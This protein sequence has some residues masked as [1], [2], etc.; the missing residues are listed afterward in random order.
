MTRRWAERITAVVVGVLLLAG[1]A[2]IP[3]R[4]PVH[5]VRGKSTPEQNAVRYNPPGPV[6]GASA[7]QV[8]YGFLD[9]MLAYPVG[10]DVATEFLTDRAAETW[11]PGART[12]VYTQ[13]SITTSGASGDKARE[14]V[15]LSYTADASLSARGRYNDRHGR[16]ATVR[17]GLTKVDGEWRISDLPDGTMVSKQ[18][19]EDYYVPLSLYF[20]DRAGN[21]L[22]TDPVYQPEGDQ[23]ATTLTYALLRG[24]SGLLAGEARS[25]LPRGTS[26][27]VSVPV[28]DSG[29]ANVRL[30]GSVQTLSSSEL[31]RM[32]A[33]IVWTVGQAHGVNG[34]RIIVNG[35]PLNLPG[36]AQVESTDAWSRFDPT[37]AAGNAKAFAMHHGRLRVIS[38]TSVTEFA[39]P[40]GED[41]SDIVDF[42]VDPSLEKIAVVPPGRTS[43]QVASLSDREDITTVATGSGFLRPVWDL[44]DRLWLVERSRDSSTLTVIDD[45]SVDAVPLG[46]LARMVVTSFELS[47]DNTRFVAVARRGGRKKSVRRV[48][49]GAIRHGS[50]GDISGLANVRALRLADESVTGP[51]SATWRSSVGVVVLASLDG[52]YPQP[53]VARIDGSTV[54]GGPLSREP[55]LTDVGATSVVCSGVLAAPVY[56]A[57]RRGRL[58]VQDVNGRWEQMPGTPLRMVSYS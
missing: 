49:V 8:V 4:G 15:R 51:V 17:F 1:C 44:Q 13:P 9:A 58:W 2:T 37:G 5:D 10:T 23:L 33:Q 25:Y 12:Q 53:Y 47:P 34:V 48:Y 57:D 30:R 50:D 42:R 32:A 31:S 11:K 21:R 18:F 7:S 16:D 39:G 27:D 54:S 43:V 55:L 45:G 26:L 41:R 56:V 29:V 28:S 38:G 36:V 22:V 40:W 6:P 46:P 35:A 52:S 24:P 19:F 20:F 3:H 14:S